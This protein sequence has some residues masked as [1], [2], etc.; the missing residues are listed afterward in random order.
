[1]TKRCSQI[2]KIFIFTLLLIFLTG[3]SF[4][5]TS[6]PTA[7]AK[8]QANT[9]LQCIKENDADTL[10]SLF[11][12]EIQ[13]MPGFDEQIHSFLSYID[14]AIVSYSGPRGGKGSGEIRDGETVNQELTGRIYN[15]QTDSGKNYQIDH[16]AILIDEN[17]SDHVGVYYIRI[18]DMDLVGTENQNSGEGEC[19]VGN[20][21]YFIY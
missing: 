19:I 18:Q 10:K 3:C 6:S 15:I 16:C 7:V 8:E 9:I 21:D 14:G 5:G 2:F 1:M 4:S 17:D 20:A 12:P 11:V 13:E